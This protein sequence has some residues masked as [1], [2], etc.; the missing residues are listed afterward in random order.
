[1]LTN[2]PVVVIVHPITN[3]LPVTVVRWQTN[4]ISVAVGHTNEH[5]GVWVT[6]E[7][8]TNIVPVFP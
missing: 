5:G 2:P 6:G 3:P 7:T 8:Q 4:I 1:V